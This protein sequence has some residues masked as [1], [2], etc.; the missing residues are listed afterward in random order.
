[1][2][3]IKLIGSI[4]VYMYLRDHNPPHFHIIYAEYE[5]LIELRSLAT[6][7]GGVPGKQRRQ[8]VEWAR[9]HMDYLLA[10]WE[11]FNPE[12]KKMEDE[13]H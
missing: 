12:N 10:K 13:N 9:E 8:V 5:E 1:M 6:Y 2:P 3:L 7:S 11:E 4:K